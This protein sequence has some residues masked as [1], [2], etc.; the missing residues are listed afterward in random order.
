[1]IPMRSCVG[2]GDRAAQSALVRFTWRE[3]TLRLDA[4]HR[5]EGRGAYLHREP[6]CW[7]AFCARRGAVRSFRAAVPRPAREQ[8]VAALAG[9]VGER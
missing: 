9:A 4:K 6:R 5:A 3:G 1:M 8:L 7:T 2:C